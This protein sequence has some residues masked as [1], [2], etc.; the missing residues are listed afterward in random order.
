MFLDTVNGVQ[1]LISPQGFVVGLMG[2]QA[3][4]QSTLNK[5]I[6]GVVGTQ[7]SIAS[8]NYSSAELQTLAQA[9]IDVITNPLPRGAVFGCRFGRNTSSNAVIHGD[10]YTRMTNYIAAT[11]NAGMGIYVGELQSPDTRRRA[12]IT[13][14]SFLQ[15][16]ADQGL[17]G[18]AD[19]TVPYQTV[20]DT[21]NNPQTRV[22]LGYMQAD[23]KV[24]YLSVI[25][26][27]IVNLEGGQSVQISRQSTTL[28][29]AY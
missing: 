22:A 4:H 26:Y 7:K 21:T 25:E 23:V 10:N 20:L 12:K 16:L 29:T 11:L 2:N 3:P 17:I 24:V 18:T 14:D 28:N 27:F 5:P 19:G 13:L 1:R 8:Q 6:Y 9:G 15:A